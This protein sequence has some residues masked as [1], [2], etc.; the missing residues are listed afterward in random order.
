MFVQIHSN[1][2]RAL[3]TRARK[4]YSRLVKA[5]EQKNICNEPCVYGTI[6]HVVFIILPYIVAY[7]RTWFRRC[8]A[9]IAQ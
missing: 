5:Y 1:S 4:L 6:K 3:A 2:L 8:G 7:S 9:H